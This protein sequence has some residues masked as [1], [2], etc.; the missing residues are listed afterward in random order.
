[1]AAAPDSPDGLDAAPADAALRGL[2]R[3]LA[4]GVIGAFYISHPSTEPPAVKI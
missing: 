1:V 3:F 4:L 2:A